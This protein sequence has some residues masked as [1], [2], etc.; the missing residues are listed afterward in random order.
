MG[1]GTW[2]Y[3]LGVSSIVD[4]FVRSEFGVSSWRGSRVD[5][6]LYLLSGAI[7]GS[8]VNEIIQN[9]KWELESSCFTFDLVPLV[10]R[11]VCI[12]WMIVESLKDEKMYVKFSNNVKAEHRGSY[13]DVEGIKWSRWMKLF[14]EYGFEVQYHMGRENVVVES[15]SRKKSEAKNEF[16]IDVDRSKLRTEKDVKLIDWLEYRRML[17]ASFGSK[18]L[19]YWKWKLSIR[20][21]QLW[22]STGEVELN[23]SNL[24]KQQQQDMPSDCGPR[25]HELKRNMIVLAKVR[26]DSKRGPEFTWER[27]DQMRSKCLQLLVAI[28][29][30]NASAKLNI[31]DV[32]FLM[33]DN[34][35]N[36]GL[37]RLSNTVSDDFCKILGADQTPC[38]IV[39]IVAKRPGFD[40][41]PSMTI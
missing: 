11:S 16:W 10:V 35:D 30:I 40:N 12:A 38:D 5:G 17:I 31:S 1:R 3:S 8:E 39:Y 9:P 27:K 15:W 21:Y 24:Y 28:D 34:C 14:S 18:C 23:G 37:H 33:W 25:G 2:Y 13:L 29:V 4:A 20:V 7:D 22:L 41:D 6:R 26:E 32:D 36:H 19:A